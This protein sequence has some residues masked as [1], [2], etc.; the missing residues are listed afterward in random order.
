MKLK[1]IANGEPVPDDLRE[2][3]VEV[4]G[5]EIL[6]NNSSLNWLGFRAGVAGRLTDDGIDVSTRRIVIERDR[7][8]FELPSAHRMALHEGMGEDGTETWIGLSTGADGSLCQVVGVEEREDVVVIHVGSE[9]STHAI[10]TGLPMRAVT[11]YPFP[12]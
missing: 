5:D 7:R 11:G 4:T 8:E 10:G 1:P 12:K 6:D 9:I 3:V 2:T